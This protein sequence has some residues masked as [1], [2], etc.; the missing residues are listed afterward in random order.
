MRVRTRSTVCR[1]PREPAR[2]SGGAISLRRNYLR[3]TVGDVRPLR[4]CARRRGAARCVQRLPLHDLVLC[5]DA[6][7]AHDDFD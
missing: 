6:R 2:W 4:N 7:S 5:G 3:L 1:K